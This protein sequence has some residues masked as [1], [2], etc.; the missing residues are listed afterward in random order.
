MN[1]SES[2]T[3]AI[4]A[5]A[6]HYP[7]PAAAAIEAL[8]IIQQHRRWVSDEALRAVA[9]LLAMSPADLDGVATFYN[10]IYRKPVGEQ[11]IHYCDSVSCW[12]MGADA[13]RDHLARRLRIGLGETTADGRFTLLPICCLGACDHAPAL[14][15]GGEVCGDLDA[16]RVD[17]ILASNSL[18][19][20]GEGGGEGED[21][22]NEKD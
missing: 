14:M 15:M 22:E 20:L 2:E 6:R 8:Q 16:A 17:D 11:V 21:V 1:L 18:S 10:L 3:T 9:E 5:A 7:E 19:P 12:L 13:I 4:R